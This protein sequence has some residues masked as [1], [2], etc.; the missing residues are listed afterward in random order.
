MSARE[1]DAEVLGEL[2][3]FNTLSFLF[4]Y[5]RI[6]T[7]GSLWGVKVFA[8][9]GDVTVGHDTATADNLHKV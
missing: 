3:E 8:S 7:S 4:S 6:I 2:R 1:S 5:F 9:R